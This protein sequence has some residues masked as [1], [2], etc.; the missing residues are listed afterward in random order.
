MATRV[1]YSPIYKYWL[2]KFHR[3]FW[4]S[5]YFQIRD[6]LHCSIWV[7]DDGTR[8]CQ[9]ADMCFM[10][11]DGRYWFMP[12]TRPAMIEPSNK[13]FELPRDTVWIRNSRY[14]DDDRQPFKRKLHRSNRCVSQ[15]LSSTFLKF[16]KRL[17]NTFVLEKEL[18]RN[19]R[20]ISS[21]S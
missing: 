14:R 5:S 4:R 3:L 13:S 19:T 2:T 11:W 9:W 21:L 20:S 12:A 1:E 18:L 10:L 8:W 6:M 7:Y 15:Y 17:T 16:G